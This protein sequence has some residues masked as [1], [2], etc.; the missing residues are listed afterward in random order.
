M[1]IPQSSEPE[2]SVI[3]KGIIVK[4]VIHT[5]LRKQKCFLVK[6]IAMPLPG[7]GGAYPFMYCE[8][9]SLIMVYASSMGVLLSASTV[10][11]LKLFF[12]KFRIE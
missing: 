12:V 11:T 8:N 6:R 9:Q 1:R 5:F 4:G 10:I 7:K 3:F 2:E